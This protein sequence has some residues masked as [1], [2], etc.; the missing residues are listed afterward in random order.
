MSAEACT[1]ALKNTLNEIRNVCPEI[2]HAF[3]FKENGEILAEDEDTTEVTANN[4]QEA[5]RVLAERANVVGGIQAVSLKGADAK[6]NITRFDNLYV[7]T[8]ASNGADE[9]TVSNL[10]RV[11]IPTTLRLVQSISSSFKPARVEIAVKPD[12]QISPIPESHALEVEASE[13]TVENLTGFGGFLNDPETAYIDSALIVQWAEVY[14]DKHITK[15]TLEAPST[16]KSMQCKF[17]P[18]KDTKYENK[19]IVQLPEKIQAA[20]RIQKGIQIL[21]KPLLEGQEETPAVTSE[22]SDEPQEV[23]Q[24][25]KPEVPRNFEGY[26]RDATVSQF[27]VENLRGIGGLL[28]NP[29]YVRVDG[30]IAAQ[31]N[32]KYG[33]KKIKEV[34][35]EETVMGKRIR[36]KYQTIKDSQF[37]GKGV[38]QLPEKMQA[39][40][41]TKKGALVMVKP[42]VD[43]EE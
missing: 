11:M 6:V 23:V 39:A 30:A 10:T 1:L 5:F 20:L 8:V 42:V 36:A 15:I 7:T 33:D 17:R 24:T 28:G 32:E 41:R 2:T 19:G 12:S 27:M 25:S 13:F 29:D 4:A 40:L 9:K 18:F 16:G 35:I 38:I 14:G 43:T 26:M 21:I 37:E 3:V 31:W 22:T 34:I